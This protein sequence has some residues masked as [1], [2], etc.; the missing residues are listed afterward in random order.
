MTTSIPSELKNAIV[1]EAESLKVS[2]NCYD[3]YS[4]GVVA[5]PTEL[6][7]VIGQCLELFESVSGLKVQSLEIDNS[8]R[9][10]YF[11]VNADQDRLDYKAELADFNGRDDYEITITFAQ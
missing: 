8:G 4:F 5:T 2:Q 11:N 1:S 3:G 6:P 9:N 10:Y 7:N